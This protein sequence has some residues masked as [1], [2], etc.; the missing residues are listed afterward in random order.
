L[1]SSRFSGLYGVETVAHNYFAAENRAQELLR[2]WLSLGQREQYDAR[3]FFE[4][5]G[6]DT[7]KRYRIY[8]GHVFNIQELD[9]YGEEAFAWCLTLHGF[10]TGDVNLAQKIALEAFEMKALAHLAPSHPIAT[11]VVAVSIHSLQRAPLQRRRR[12][13]TAAKIRPGML[14]GHGKLAQI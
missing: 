1:S 9:A 13:V 2:S 12:A 4:V 11:I 6:S 14:R 7:R 5:V 10:A 3:G 8:R